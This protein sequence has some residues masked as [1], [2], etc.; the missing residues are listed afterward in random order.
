[1]AKRA[2]GTGTLRKRAD[3]RWEGRLYLGKDENGKNQ[4]KTVTSKKKSECQNKLDMMIAQNEKQKRNEECRYGDCVNPTVEEWNEIYIEDFCTGYLKPKTI[5][6]Y[7]SIIKNYINP[8]L[9]KYHLRDLSKLICQQYIMDVYENGR[10]NQKRA[11]DIAQGLSSRTV[12]DIKIVLHAS[13]EK[14][15]DE[16]IIDKNPT[17]KLNMPKDRVKGMTTLTKEQSNRL[18]EEAFNS[19]CFEFYYLELTTGLRLGEILALEWDDLDVKNKTLSISKQV[20]RIK[21]EGMVLETPKTKNSIR[22]IAL[23]SN[24]VMV[25]ARL[26]LQQAKGTTLMFPSPLTGTYRDSNSVTRRFKRMLRRAGLP[27]EVRFH[28]LRH[29]CATIGLEEKIEVKALSSMLGHSD[30]AFTMNTYVHA[31]KKLKTTA[32]DKMEAAFQIGYSSVM[33]AECQLKDA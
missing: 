31:T 15:V 8:Y 12:K 10:V 5:S 4:Y 2:K 24:C 22:T 16:G 6:G 21:G 19:G 18:L 13:L 26:K 20:Q 30:V 28:D 11:S 27:Q 3:G 1:M 9:G 17:N 14:A 33:N 32:A 23:S 25:L 29:T 7:K